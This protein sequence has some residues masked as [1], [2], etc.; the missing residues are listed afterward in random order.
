M[1]LTRNY[2][3]SA[4]ISS[5]NQQPSSIT[6]R[7]EAVLMLSNVD[8]PSGQ[9]LLVQRH[10]SRHTFRPAPTSLS[11]SPT[12]PFALLRSLPYPRRSSSVEAWRWRLVA[13]VLLAY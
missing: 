3:H 2:M 12:S 8:G 7:T 11:P 4:C 10:K 1:H 9:L 13:R 5:I 6:A